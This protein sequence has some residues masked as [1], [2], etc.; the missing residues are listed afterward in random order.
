MEK[1]YQD[2][3]VAGT[4]NLY[5]GLY[6]LVFIYYICFSTE[7]AE[8]GLKLVRP[9]LLVRHMLRV[10]NK[11]AFCCDIATRGL[12]GFRIEVAASKIYWWCCEQRYSDR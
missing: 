1:I 11:P 4:K 3:I 10:H 9:S 8:C 7:C 2:F 5:A 12:P 6:V